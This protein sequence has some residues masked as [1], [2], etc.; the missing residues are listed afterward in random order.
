ML[1][2]S[3]DEGEDEKD[4]SHQCNIFHRWTANSSYILFLSET[5][6][7][8]HSWGLH[9]WQFR[10]WTFTESNDQRWRSSLVEI[11]NS[12]GTALRGD[13]N[14]VYHMNG[15]TVDVHLN[16]TAHQAGLRL[17]LGGPYDVPSKDSFLSTNLD[18]SGKITDTA[19]ASVKCGHNMYLRVELPGISLKHCSIRSRLWHEKFVSFRLHFSFY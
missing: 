10:R 15:P 16:E 14:L 6:S 8:R 3:N 1:I 12:T 13:E 7:S 9:T 4:S 18:S 19:T 11:L 17:Y 5:I 2:K